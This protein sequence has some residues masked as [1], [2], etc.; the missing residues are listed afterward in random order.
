MQPIHAQRIALV[1]S[2]R[3]QWVQTQPIVVVEVFV[4]Q[5]QTVEPLA[6]QL[7]DGVICITQIAAIVE[8]RCQRSRDSQRLIHLAQQQDS[9]ITG[10]RAA[11]KIGR[12][13]SPSEVLKK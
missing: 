7:L 6:H 11:G 5:S 3:Q 10:E 2:H 8:A 9:A 1:A 4:T 13:L 12:H